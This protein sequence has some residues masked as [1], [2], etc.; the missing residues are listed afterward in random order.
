MPNYT[1]YRAYKKQRRAVGAS[2]WED[3]VPLTLSIDGDGTMRPIVLENQSDDCG[4]APE[5]DPEYKWVDIDP[6]VDWICDEEPT[7]IYDWKHLNPYEDYY[8]DEPTPYEYDFKLKAIF[9]DG[10]ESSVTCDSSAFIQ[11][12]TVEIYSAMTDV[13]IGD[14]TNVLEDSLSYYYPYK[15]TFI[16]F[17]NLS[18]V[19]FSKHLFCIG[20]NAFSGCTALKDIEI[21]NNVIEIKKHAF[22]NCTNLSGVTLPNN[23]TAIDDG[24]FYN[25]NSLQNVTIPNSVKKI[26]S[27]YEYYEYGDYPIY[28]VTDYGAFENCESLSNVVLPKELKEINDHAFKNCHSLSSIEIPSTVEKIGLGAFGNCSSLTSVTIPASVEIICDAAFSDCTSMK[29]VKI[30]NGVKHIDGFAF[31]NCSSLTSVTIPASVESIE[32][33]VFSGCTSLKYIIMK[34]TT[35]PVLGAISKIGIPYYSNARPFDDT[36]GCRIYVPSS[37]LNAYKNADGWSFYRSRIFPK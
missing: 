7:P 12:S 29:K 37:A 22:S 2:T 20:T 19:T 36:N 3:V 13:I 17:P 30:S 32:E 9:G 21:P 1:K 10:S 15:G 16:G 27:S 5:E 6:S 4:W 24:V 8:C 14:C 11:N 25:C 33:L 34:P 28:V 35:P 23:L 31:Y 18:G 26:S